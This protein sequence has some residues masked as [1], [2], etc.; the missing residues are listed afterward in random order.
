MSDAREKFALARRG[1]P[2]P[3]GP[4]TV[5]RGR[6]LPAA[7]RNPAQAVPEAAQLA[8][9]PPEAEQE[10]AWRVE[11][12]EWVPRDDADA[13]STVSPWQPGPATQGVTS[14][15]SAGEVTVR[16]AGTPSPAWHDAPARRA[17]GAPSPI[18]SHAR[19]ST[20][21][22]DAADGTSVAAIPAVA[23][24]PAVAP[25]P[26]VTVQ[27]ARR[28]EGAQDPAPGN[29][30]PA[31]AP[32]A[33][34]TSHDDARAAAAAS[35]PAAAANI[36]HEPAVVMRSGR[37][38]QPSPP[39]SGHTAGPSV[40]VAREAGG[41]LPESFAPVAVAID[42]SATPPT[43]PLPGT[44]VELHAMGAPRPVADRR[45]SEPIDM[46]A[47]LAPVAKPRA[48]VCIDSVSVTVQA[49]ASPTAQPVTPAPAAAVARGA[50]AA[51]S[52]RNPWAG[53]H[54]RRD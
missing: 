37:M 7:A 43:R 9:A 26:A 15:A 23:A 6:W 50:P 48:E 39:G 21:A 42:T 10:D 41:T 4:R 35:A 30:I 36:R 18:R 28:S 38:L 8:P 22:G 20:S 34:S 19:S 40:T 5:L 27:D 29:R 51:R 3:T 49:S 17:S 44:I 46:A 54:A 31:A 14:P 25:Q 45:L 1:L 12:A 33:Q 16:T 53:Y 2:L 47:L 11:A 52:F 32:H 24:M 13:E